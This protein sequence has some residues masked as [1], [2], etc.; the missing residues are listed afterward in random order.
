MR[1]KDPDLMKRIAAYIGRFYLANDRTP[2]TTEIAREMGISRSTAYYYLVAMDKA[3]MLDYV[4]GTI[5]TSSMEKISIEREPVESVGDIACGDPTT[6]EENVEFI[7][8]LPTAIFGKG[9]FFILHA[10]GDSMVDEGIEEGDILVIR[11]TQEARIGDIVVALDGNNQNTLKKYGGVSATN[12]KAMLEYC[13]VEKYG[14]KT[15][16][17]DRLVCQG[18]LSHVIKE[19]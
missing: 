5:K 18:I 2:S 14:H 4:D 12:G 8:S 10:K 13:N 3:D 11:K 9:P 7:T 19:K 1:H 16:A 15:I 6:E 17:V